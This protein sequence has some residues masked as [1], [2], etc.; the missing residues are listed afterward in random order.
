MMKDLSV[1]KGYDKDISS[2]TWHPVHPAL[3]TAGGSDGSL[4][5]YLLNQ[6][7]TTNGPNKTVMPSASVPF[8][9]EYTIWAMEYHPLGHI[10][11]TGSNDRITRFWSRPRPGE[12]D[13]FH[14]R[15]HLGEAAVDTGGGG[16]DNKARN[17][18]GQQYKDEDHEGDDD[19]AD[20]LVDQ[21]M[22]I[23]GGHNA[24]PPGFSDLANQMQMQQGGSMG[25]GPPGMNMLM[26]PGG[27]GGG[28][29]GLG[30]LAGL[31]A[32]FLQHLPPPPPPPPLVPIGSGGSGGVP[33]LGNLAGL[34]ANFLQHLPPPP[35]P[36]P[37]PGV[38][39]G[40]GGGSSNN[41]IPG[42]P[43]KYM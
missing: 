33:G 9:H 5:H 37:P 34:S 41:M 39:I 35:L 26:M 17:R 2:L 18:R 38:A 42:L 8:A 23:P 4:H 15:Y 14:D 24:F 20:A 43:N 27:G 25:D 30:N 32:D 40:G 12:T 7:V 29:P 6:N 3:L 19:N 31:P 1:L 22:P 36:P 16:H 21:K 10:L 28:V 11:C 13:S